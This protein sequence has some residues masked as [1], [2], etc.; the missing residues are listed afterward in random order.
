MG[1]GS[2]Q[3]RSSGAV[4]TIGKNNGQECGLVMSRAPER[5]QGSAK[6]EKSVTGHQNN[7]AFRARQLGAESRAAAPAAR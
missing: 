5:R 4:R 3:A 7:V 1:I 2:S 6:H